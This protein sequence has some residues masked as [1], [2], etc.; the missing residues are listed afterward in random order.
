[1]VRCKVLGVL[2][3]NCE[4]RGTLGRGYSSN[5]GGGPLI[6]YQPVIIR[7]KIKKGIQ[8]SIHAT[9]Y[10]VHPLS[11]KLQTPYHDHDHNHNHNH[12]HNRS[13]SCLKSMPLRLL[14]FPILIFRPANPSCLTVFSAH[15][16]SE[17]FCLPPAF[18]HNNPQPTILQDLP[19]TVR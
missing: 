6:H 1:M 17:T 2:G 5:L 14:D 11:S 18:S 8:Y 7:P 4:S 16:T 9:S 13:I 10:S 15:L 12:N 3:S 19:P